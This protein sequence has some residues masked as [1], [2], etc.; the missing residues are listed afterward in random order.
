[1]QIP[2]FRPV[3]SEEAIQAVAEVLRSGWIGLGPVTAEFEGAF[4]SYVD[5]PHC[6]ALSSGTAVLHLAL[7]LLDLQPGDE[8]VT[9]ALTFVS[10]NHAILYEG[11]TP[12]F[13]D[14]QERTGNLD[15]GSIVGRFT[16][17]TRAVL[18]LHYAG[19]P[20][21]LDEIYAAADAAGVAVIEDCAHATGASYRGRR[22]GSHGGLHA[23]SFH[24][25]KN[26][27]CG[28][29]GALTLTSA[30]HRERA[31]RLR[32]LGIDRDTFGRLSETGYRWEYAVEEVGFKYH[33]SDVAAAIGLAQ[34]RLLDEENGR[35]DAI[36]EAYSQRLTG[37]PGLQLLERA[38][39]RTCSNHLFCVLVD[40]QAGV[41]ERLAAAGIGCSVH[42]KRNDGYAM[43]QDADLPLTESFSR[44]VVSLPMHLALNDDD[45]EYVCD[46]LRTG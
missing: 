46:V 21:D 31:R 45:V 13:A 9:T 29:G 34:L 4:A 3:V 6:V 32:W 15:P 43:F 23:F 1:M 8:V 19:Y 17:R 22:I 20:C 28:E 36:A 16:E 42:Y 18:L 33:M 25:V 30:E 27:T 41:V 10:A 24:A 40:D 26:L 39:D 11:A 12:V 44:R 38:D 35:R 2:L 7:R 5:A 37:T 14:I